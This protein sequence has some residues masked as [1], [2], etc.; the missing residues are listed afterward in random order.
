VAIPI[1]IEIDSETAG[2][3]LTRALAV[4][5]LPA[6]LHGDEGCELTITLHHEATERLL[7]DLL[8][9]IEEWRRDRGLPAVRL[10][11]GS[12]LY[13]IAAECDVARVLSEAREDPLPVGAS[14]A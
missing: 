8:P 9:A 2:Y 3:D 6:E 7:A 11:L 1:A 12:R 4:R 13:S 5:G 14:T 10:R